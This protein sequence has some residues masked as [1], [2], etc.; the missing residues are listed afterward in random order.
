MIQV[1]MIRS[2]IIHRMLPSLKIFISCL[3]EHEQEALERLEGPEGVKTYA[4]ITDFILAELGH[5]TV[6]GAE[7][8]DNKSRRIAA[9]AA[10]I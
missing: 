6:N 4:R 9:R 1:D 8:H 5:V 7:S 10:R 2:R 3:P